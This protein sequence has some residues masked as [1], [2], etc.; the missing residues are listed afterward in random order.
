[1]LELFQQIAARGGEGVSSA[2][3]MVITKDG[4]LIL[5]QVA[6]DHVHYILYKVPLKSY[7]ELIEEADELL[8]DY[9]PSDE[10]LTRYRMLE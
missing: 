4:K 9:R 7:D 5:F 2:V 1:M 10:I 3:R 8:K 6:P